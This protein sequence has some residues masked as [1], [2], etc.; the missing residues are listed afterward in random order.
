MINCLLKN[1]VP[2]KYNFEY[3]DMLLLSQLPSE[4]AEF[5]MSSLSTLSLYVVYEYL[6]GKACFIICT[7]GIDNGTLSLCMPSATLSSH[8][9]DTTFATLTCGV[10][11][12]DGTQHSFIFIYIYKT[13]LQSTAIIV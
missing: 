5:V 3:N 2:V 9:D 10:V 13:Y 6:F 1:N 11:F 4:H 8:S 7:R 12:D